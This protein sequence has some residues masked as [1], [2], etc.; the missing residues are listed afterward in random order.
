MEMTMYQFTDINIWCFAETDQLAAMK[1][2]LDKHNSKLHYTGVFSRLMYH[3][4]KFYP[5]SKSVF[6]KIFLRTIVRIKH[7]KMNICCHKKN[8]SNF[9]FYMELKI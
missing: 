6:G 5:I 9:F 1:A 3:K 2:Y 7:R 8:F 4:I